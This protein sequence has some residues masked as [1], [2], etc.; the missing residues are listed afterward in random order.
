MGKLK[1][2]I[3]PI[4][5]ILYIVGAFLYQPVISSYRMAYHSDDLDKHIGIVEEYQ[6]KKTWV[7]RGRGTTNKYQYTI[8]TIN[9]E[10]GRFKINVNKPRSEVEAK[11]PIGSEIVYY[12]YHGHKGLTEREAY[13]PSF[14]IYI[15]GAIGIVLFLVTGRSIGLGKKEN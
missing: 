11:N 5:L 6:G 14:N 9:G 8:V 2:V 10:D 12:D 4:I 13:T 1:S 3:M 7:L 15:V